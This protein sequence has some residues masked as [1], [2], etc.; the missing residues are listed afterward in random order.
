MKSE[1]SNQNPEQY[2]LKIKKKSL[3]MVKKADIA[4]L[5]RKDF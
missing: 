1:N 5:V 2:K 3:E 4:S